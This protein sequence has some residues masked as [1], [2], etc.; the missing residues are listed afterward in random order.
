MTKEIKKV[1]VTGGGGQISY[2]LLFRIANG[3]L[4]GFDQPV[5]LYIH[6]LP[7]QCDSVLKGVVM[8]LED[9]SYPLLHEVVYSSD[10]HKVF[11][12]ANYA[13]LIGSKPRGPGMERKDLLLENGSIFQ[14]QGKILNEVAAKD[15]L[16]FVVGN[17]CNTNCLIAMSNAPGIPR[18]NFHAMTRLDQNRAYFQLAKKAGVKLTDIENITIWGNHSSTQ[19]P[20][21][22]NAKILDQ[23][24]VNILKDN[25][26]LENEFYKVIQQ[27]G[28]EIIKVRG[29]SSAASAS[30]AIIDAIKDLTTPSKKGKWFSSAICSDNNPYGIKEGLVFS[31][32]CICNRKKEVKVVD[33]LTIDNFMR[34]KIK[35]TEKELLEEKEVVKHLL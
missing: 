31:F 19:V 3:D 18:K 4:L 6:D 2:N 9:G 32:P 16:V 23:P 21:F 22:L 12:G 26:W 8:E 35:I 17:P 30:Q 14:K 5:S 27:R 15:V 25:E 33:N 29:K 24:L 1:A 34:E 20:D 11:N 7:E 28:A 10:L 13:I